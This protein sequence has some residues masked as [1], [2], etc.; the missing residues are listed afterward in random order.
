MNKTEARFVQ[1][2]L[3]PLKALKHI[4]SYQF[5][6]VKV[7][8]GT[9]RCWLTVDFVVVWHDGSIE[10]IDVK[11][12]GPHEDDALV[13]IKAAAKQFPEYHWSWWKYQGKNQRW[14]VTRFGDDGTH[15]FGDYRPSLLEL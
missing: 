3:E 7:C 13:K 15:P 4:V 14:K 10:Y 9:D 12:G 8:V 1:E 11:G 6:A 5:E 2:Y